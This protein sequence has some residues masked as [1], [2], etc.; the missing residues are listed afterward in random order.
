M[1]CVQSVVQHMLE[2]YPDLAGESSDTSMTQEQFDEI[3]VVKITPEILGKK[4]TNILCFSL[5]R[6]GFH[7]NVIFECQ[8][9]TLKNTKSCSG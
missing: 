4:F 6:K 7:V 9:D 2:V 3:P 1:T 5:Y 8:K